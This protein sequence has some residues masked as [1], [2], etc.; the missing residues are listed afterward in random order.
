MSLRCACGSDDVVAVSPGIEPVRATLR[1]WLGLPGMSE[2]T[3][4][5]QAMSLLLSPG[6]PTRAWCPACWPWKG[7]TR[8]MD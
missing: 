8:G 6:E 5:R 3:N 1:P 2:R 7:G 4:R